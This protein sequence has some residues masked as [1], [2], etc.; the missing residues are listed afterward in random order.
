MK[1]SSSDKQVADSSRIYPSTI[2]GAIVHR[3]VANHGRRQQR[4]T[5]HTY[6]YS[7]ATHLPESATDLR[8]IRVLPG[9]NTS[10][11][12]EIYTHVAH[13][14]FVGIKNPLDLD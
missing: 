13:S 1:A 6:W 3:V 12:T 4:L 10:R 7:F 11:S 14:N 9:H 2:I 5:Q 8:Y